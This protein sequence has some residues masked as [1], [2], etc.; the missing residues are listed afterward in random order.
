MTDGSSTR[1]GLP[2]HTGGEGLRSFPVQHPMLSHHGASAGFL[3]FLRRAKIEVGQ[4]QM[5]LMR[6]SISEILV[7]TL[8]FMIIQHVWL[9]SRNRYAHAYGRG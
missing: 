5:G 9:G 4:F 2:V 7:L 1:G 6:L 3:S 8:E